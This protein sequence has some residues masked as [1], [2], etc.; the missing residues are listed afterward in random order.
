V[1]TGMFCAIGPG[2]FLGLIGRVIG[3][4]VPCESHII[5]T[6]D[7]PTALKMRDYALRAAIAW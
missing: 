4:T 7:K 2:P 5:R 6:M 1:C 3:A